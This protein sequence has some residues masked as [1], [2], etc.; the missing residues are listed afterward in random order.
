MN[1]SKDIMYLLHNGE[2]EQYFLLNQMKEQITRRI[3]DVTCQA[4]CFCKQL[5]SFCT[6]TITAISLSCLV[7]QKERK[8]RHKGS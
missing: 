6:S 4:T 3:E 7:A 5:T 8:K 2:I 1:A